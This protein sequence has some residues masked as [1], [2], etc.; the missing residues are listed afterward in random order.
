MNVYPQ[1]YIATCR[2][3]ID[4]QLTSFRQIA[5]S[6]SAK[7]QNFERQF[8][9]HMLLALDHYFVH[10]TR[11]IEGKDGNPLNEVRM[12]CNAIMENGAVLQADKT[13]KYKPENTVLQI[14]VG[15]AVHLNADGFKK[16]A[17]AFFDEIEKKF[18]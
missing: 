7:L 15:D 6:Q 2:A 1:D 10:R 16:L 9:H 8:F 12:L 3:N 14:A 11:S 18:S 17:H 4:A 13:I 5:A